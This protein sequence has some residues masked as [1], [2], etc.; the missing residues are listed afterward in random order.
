[1]NRRELLLGILGAAVA[2]SS[3]AVAAKAIE[4]FQPLTN[5]WPVQEE[6]LFS[7]T[8]VLATLAGGEQVEHKVW[9]RAGKSGSLRM[10]LP[11]GEYT[12]TIVESA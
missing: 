2:A 3:P 9:C 6:Y 1:M 7:F 4:Q 10:G 11:P 12:A 5:L 8:A